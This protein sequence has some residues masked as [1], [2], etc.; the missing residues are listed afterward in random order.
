MKYVYYAID[1]IFNLIRPILKPIVCLLMPKKYRNEVVVRIDGG[2]CSQIHFYLIGCCFEEKGYRVLYD[3]NWF[4]TSGVDILGVHVR[5]FDLKKMC[6]YL[7]LEEMPNDIVHYLFSK[8]LK[9]D[10]DYFK[11]SYGDYSWIN[12]NAPVY[13]GGYYHDFPEIYLKMLPKYFKIEKMKECL[14]EQNVKILSEIEGSQSVAIHVRRGDLANYNTVYGVPCSIDYFVKAV[15]LFTDDNVRFFIF[16]DDPLWCTN[17]LLKY[18]PLDKDYKLV[19]INASD[20]GYMDLVLMS[21]C[22]HTIT[23]KGS[24]GKYSAM[25]NRTESRIVVLNDDKTEYMWRNIF[26]NIYF[27]KS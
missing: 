5:N 10:Y 3:L 12:E 13:M 16:S 14:D 22:T 23:S 18:L 27:I 6:P 7:E 26:K 11:V 8:C 24:L 4:R 20:K 17:E 19:D 2:I 9:S 15:N 1:L 21:Y 25:M